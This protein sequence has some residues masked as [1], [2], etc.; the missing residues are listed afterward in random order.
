[1][2]DGKIKRPCATDKEWKKMDLE[3]KVETLGNW[4]KLMTEWAE[5]MHDWTGEVKNAMFVQHQNAKG[6]VEA[7]KPWTTRSGDGG[8]PPPKHPKD[9]RC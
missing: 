8:P 4:A 3:E 9:P 1:M 7:T 6:M 5:K 2:S